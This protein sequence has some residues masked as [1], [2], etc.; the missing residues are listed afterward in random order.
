MRL[1]G[2]IGYPLTHS[3][4]GKY[5]AEK[6]AREGLTDYRYDL[7]S[8]PAIDELP[9]ILSQHPDLCGLNVTIPY[10]EQVLPFLNET[11]KVVQEIQACNCIRIK[12]GQLKGFNTDVIG[13]ETSLKEQLRPHHRKALILGTG[14][15]AKAVEFVLQKAGIEFKYVS[16]KKTA[17]NLT[18]SELDKTVVEAYQLIIN[19]TPVGTYPVINEAPDIPYDDLTSQHYLFDLVYNPAKTLFLQKGEQK[20]AVVKNGYDM[21][22]IQADESWRIWSEQ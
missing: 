3:F 5:F 1:F 16:R 18:Y 20:G 19:T 15:A 8:I 7:F 2:L 22:L 12:N 11:D 14:G 10:K 17:N 9:L 13:F 6:F 4:S 21:L